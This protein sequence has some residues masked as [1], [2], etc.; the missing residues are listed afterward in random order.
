MHAIN[1]PTTARACDAGQLNR[2]LHEGGVGVLDGVHLLHRVVLATVL[3]VV[4]HGLE[5]PGGRL[6][7]RQ[8]RRAIGGV[9]ARGRRH[10]DG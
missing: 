7:T 5:V 4:L 1:A 8:R 10:L 6:A 3:E 9:A 2:A